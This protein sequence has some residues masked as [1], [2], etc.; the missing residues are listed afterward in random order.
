M[1]RST[2]LV[3]Q[4]PPFDSAR[5]TT[6]KLMGEVT[7]ATVPVILAAVW[8]F[9]IAALLVIAASVLGAVGSEWLLGRREPGESRGR[10]LRDGSALLTGILLGL[11]LPPLLPLWMAFVGGLFA[12]GIGKL[13]LGGLGGNVFNPALVGRA[14]LQAAFP[15]A[16]TTWREPGSVGEILAL[17]SSTFAP[18]F[19]VGEVDA[20]TTATAL[21]RMKFDA[22]FAP[23][24]DLLRGNV[25]GSLGETSAGLL[26]LCGIWMGVRRLFDWRVPVTILATVAVLGQAFHWVS[27]E[28]Y[29]DGIFM[30]FS[31]GL[32]LGTVF[33]ATDPVT[34][35]TSPRGAVIF[36]LG[37]AVLVVLI[38]LF[39]GL[40]EGVMYA[41]LLMNAA[42]PLI[43]RFTQPRIFGR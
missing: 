8:F 11:T 33:M 18:P 6:P 35:P 15:T 41:I 17:S 28:K 3:L 9:G 42:T 26:L 1:T 4:S 20:V 23:W 27:P 38:R 31:G 39:G 14:F 37:I 29:P 36:G 32:L 7:L 2:E 13:A 22:E 21:S 16:L 12:I 25:A 24:L 10:S 5:L 40:P 34:S 19:A 30:L 43:E